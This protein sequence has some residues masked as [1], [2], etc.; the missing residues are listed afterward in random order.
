[1]LFSKSLYFSYAL[2]FLMGIAMAPRFFV[3]YVYAMEFLPQKN[4]GMAT[5]ITLGVDGLVLMW[6]SLY[7]MFVDNNWK[8]L[9]AIATVSTFFTILLTYI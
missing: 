8:S 1:M 5:S 7:F 3:G 9:Y 6:S 4:T 2:V